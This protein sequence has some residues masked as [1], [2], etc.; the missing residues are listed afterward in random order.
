MTA[1]GLPYILS[2]SWTCLV[3]AL[4]IFVIALS[5]NLGGDALR[6]LMEE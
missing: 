1:Q 3:P 6:D 4:A 2:A 5:S